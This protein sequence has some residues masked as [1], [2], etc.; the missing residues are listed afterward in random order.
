M[1]NTKKVSE[2]PEPMIRINTR[3]QNI[4]H[5]YIKELAKK[6]N[7][8]E[9]EMFREVLDYYIKNNKNGNKI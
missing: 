7:K 3:V 9:G 6:L 8:T 1:K 4:H 5:K 2:K